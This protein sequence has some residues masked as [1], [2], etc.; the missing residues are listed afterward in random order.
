M[1]K[2]KDLFIH[3]K[4]SGPSRSF[5]KLAT[6]FQ[7]EAVKHQNLVDIQKSLAKQFVGEKNSTKKEKLK[8]ELL[9]HH[10]V[11]KKQ[12]KVMKSA[13]QTMMNALDREEF[14][15]DI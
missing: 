3:E 5:N 10:K 9:K 6:N 12:E 4:K 11:V 13:E 15:Y 7:K 14:D 2:L 1:I 8:Q